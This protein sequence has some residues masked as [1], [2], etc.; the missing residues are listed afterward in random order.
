[1]SN[2]KIDFKLLEQ[3]KGNVRPNVDLNYTKVSVPL[4]PGQ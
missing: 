1:M 3:I 4:P 2:L